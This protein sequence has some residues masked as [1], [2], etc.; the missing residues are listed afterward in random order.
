MDIERL[1]NQVADYLQLT[2]LNQRWRGVCLVQDKIKSGVGDVIEYCKDL[3]EAFMQSTYFDLARFDDDNIKNYGTPFVGSVGSCIWL[4]ANHYNYVLKYETSFPTI[5]QRYDFYCKIFQAHNDGEEVNEYGNIFYYVF[6]DVY[7]TPEFELCKQIKEFSQRDLD[8]ERMAYFER[9]AE[10]V[11]LYIALQTEK[12]KIKD[13]AWVQGVQ[14]T[15]TATDAPDLHQEAM[16]PS[17]RATTPKQDKTASKITETAKERFLSELDCLQEERIAK[18]FQRAID[19]GYMCEVDDGYKWR[20]GRTQKTQCA[21]FLYE[22]L[23]PDGYDGCIFPLKAVSE[24]FGINAKS[25]E[26]SNRQARAH[27]LCKWMEQ[28]DIDIFFD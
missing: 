7:G 1:Y 26:S 19:K 10:L 18:Y 17:E 11:F 4:M 22:V 28:M 25:L 23:K 6:Y 8:F 15:E 9:E 20:N 14:L 24:L 12:E 21:Y 2:D 5:Q 3:M 13:E 16:K 27:S